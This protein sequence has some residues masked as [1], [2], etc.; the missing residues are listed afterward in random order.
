[1]MFTNGKELTTEKTL[2][3]V[4]KGLLESDLPPSSKR[5]VLDVIDQQIQEGKHDLGENGYLSTRNAILAQKN[6]LL[7]PPKRRK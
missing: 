7:N 1:M 2:L 5:I 4:I 3:V 6:Y